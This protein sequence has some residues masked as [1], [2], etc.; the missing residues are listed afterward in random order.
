M[1][2]LDS[3]EMYMYVGITSLHYILHLRIGTTFPIMQVICISPA[4]LQSRTGEVKRNKKDPIVESIEPIIF[5]DL[6]SDFL[7][8]WWNKKFLLPPPPPSPPMSFLLFY[9]SQ[10]ILS[11]SIIHPKT[12]AK[13]P[14]RRRREEIYA[15]AGNSLSFNSRNN[16][17]KT[18]LP[19]DLPIGLRIFSSS[20]ST[21]SAHLI[22]WS[23]VDAAAGYPYF[24]L[25]RSLKSTHG[26]LPVEAPKIDFSIWF[27]VKIV[28]CPP[29]MDPTTTLI[30]F[31]LWVDPIPQCLIK[32]L[33]N[34]VRTWPRN[35]SLKAKE[36]GTLFVYRVYEAR[37]E[38]K[39]KKIF[40]HV[41]Q[42]TTFWATLYFGWIIFA[43]SLRSFCP[44]YHLWILL[45]EAMW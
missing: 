20:P 26:L 11:D 13:I 25:V 44:C 21:T 15:I 38:R 27:I 10:D 30:T 7:C 2:L 43:R 45:V 39:Q 16:S 12:K 23:H 19:L 5:N 37:K 35:K 1:H 4:T 36:E 3:H 33:F 29:A 24:K 9:T 32:I 6:N 22:S 34:I 31:M 18:L 8:S 41:L 17:L 28:T 40:Q 42:K 14:W